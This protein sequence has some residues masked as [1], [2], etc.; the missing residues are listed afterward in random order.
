MLYRHCFSFFALRYAIRKVQENRL[1]LKLSGTHRI[2]AHADNVNLWGDNI[3]AI[4][5]KQKI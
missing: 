2:L 3:D 1:Q 5:R 4:E